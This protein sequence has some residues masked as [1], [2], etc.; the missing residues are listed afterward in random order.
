[1]L[2]ERS[3]WRWKCTRT[4]WLSTRHPYL[5]HSW[6]T[7]AFH[8]FLLLLVGDAFQTMDDLSGLDWNSKSAD[9][10]PLNSYTTHLPLRP[11]PSPSNSGRSTPLFSQ[12][13]GSR[14]A[15][16][17]QPV[18]PSNDDSFSS[19]LA[20]KPAKPAGSL[21]LLEKQR[22]LQGQGNQHRISGQQQQQ[23]D[24]YNA[25]DSQFWEGLGSGRG[26][27]ASVSSIPLVE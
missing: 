10:P 7:Q 8:N 18:K 13:S 3:L 15:S 17:Q 2:S 24:P 12:V 22:Q 4:P 14:A 27:P 19:L 16:G 23:Q 11:S 9:K 26:T 1:M 5:Q 25:G 6:Y 21:S 20:P